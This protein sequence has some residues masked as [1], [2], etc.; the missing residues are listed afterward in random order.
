VEQ[1]SSGAWRNSNAFLLALA[2]AF[3]GLTVGVVVTVAV[4]ADRSDPIERANLDAVEQTP[5][6]KTILVRLMAPDDGCWTRTITDELKA[7]DEVKEDCGAVTFTVP[8]RKDI[9]ISFERRP[10]GS[11][12]WCLVAAVDGKLVLTRGPDSN[13]EYGMDVY[14]AIPEPGWEPFHIEPVSCAEE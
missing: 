13:P 11:W 1:R 5:P 4:L 14:W 9:N 8:V 10:P 12:T 2:A 3:A 6:A 7:E